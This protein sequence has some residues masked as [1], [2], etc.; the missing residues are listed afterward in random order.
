MEE[1]AE[2]MRCQNLDWLLAQKLA[3]ELAIS[4]NLKK[5]IDVIIGLL[6]AEILIRQMR[7][8]T[9][10]PDSRGMGVVTEIKNE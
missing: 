2:K 9:E 7:G 6:E 4:G 8:E 1:Y 5:D 10:T 3:F